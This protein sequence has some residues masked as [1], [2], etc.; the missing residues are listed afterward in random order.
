MW[1]KTNRIAAAPKQGID[2]SSSLKMGNLIAGIDVG[3]TKVA[4][5]IA[6]ATGI[7]HKL[8]APVA[9]SGANTAIA[10]Q[11]WGLIA[12]ACAEKNLPQVSIQA[13]GISTC[14]PFID[15]ID[16]LG[17][18]TRE[19]TAPNLCG[20]MGGNPYQLSNDWKSFPLG[21]FFTDKV[22]QVVM[23][24]DA[25]ATLQAERSF[26]AARGSN[27]CVYA[28]W[29][30]GIGFG[31][32]VDGQLL[33]G[34]RGNAGHAGH[35][36]FAEND[37]SICGCGNAGDMEGMLSGHALAR[38]WQAKSGVSTATTL[39]FFAA[40]RAGNADAIALV[41]QAAYRFGAVL[42]NLAVTLD[43]ELFVMGGSVFGHNQDLLLPELN[44]SLKRGMGAGM[45]VIT[46]DIRIVPAALGDR[47]ADLG[48][49]SLVM[50]KDWDTAPFVSA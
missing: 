1:Q 40:A 19:V 6:T 41:T 12:Q 9:T 7:L 21:S 44:R 36:Y 14:S 29:S 39:D 22:A 2:M 37:S 17:R 49:L 3:G 27:D 38:A 4:V 31:L 16:A 47:T 18:K 8:Q 15:I 28:T 35:S 25:V 13:V 20:G 34:K 32:C 23:Q 48:A 26:G 50:P 10:E 42:Y 45:S 24:N 33:G 46:H 5:T 30:T 43:T 11:A